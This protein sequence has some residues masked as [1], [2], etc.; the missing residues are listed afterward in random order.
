MHAPFLTAVRD[1]DGDGVADERRDLLTGLGLPPEK[2]P[3]AAA[4]R[5]RRGRRPRRLALPGPGRQRLRRPAA[6]R[7]PAGAPR[8]RHPALPARRPRPARLRDRPAEH[9]RRR[10]RRGAERLRARQR[11]RRRRLHDPR[12]PQ[13]LRRRP[14]LSVPLRRAPRRGP[15]AARRSSASGSSAGGLCY[16]EAGFPAEYRGNLF[17][18]EWG[19]AVVRYRPERS[20]Q[21]LRAARGDRVRRRG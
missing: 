15:A 19:R 2:N 6:R 9:L 5:Q 20:G 11:E 13:L 8:R 18:C 1:T 16:L 21:R 12:L 10:P 17:F 4:L 3:L 14:R 7:R